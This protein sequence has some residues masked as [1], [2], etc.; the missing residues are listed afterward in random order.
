[1]PAPTERSP[2][3]AAPPRGPARPALAAG[4]LI[5]GRYR[6]RQPVEVPATDDEPADFWRADDETLERPVAI[7]L[8]PAGGQRGKAATAP[9]LAAAGRAARL[10]HPGLA[11]VYDAGVTTLPSRRSGRP[12]DIAYVVTEWVDAPPLADLLAAGP[13]PPP[14]ATALALQAAEAL[15]ALHDAGLTHG[16]VH[17]GNLLVDGDRA[18][19]TDAVV[20]TALHDWADADPAE[21]VRDLCAVLYAM[22]T[23]RW[24]ASAT[25]QPSRGVPAAPRAAG[26]AQV[27]A[28]R[29]VR[30]GIPR[31][32][33]TLVL[34]GLQPGRGLGSGGELAA[35]L[36]A[37]DLGPPEAPPSPP[38]V[39]RPA[40]R[41][42]RRALP[43]LATV[44][45]LVL[46]GAVLYQVGQRVGQLPRRAGA[47]DELVDPTTAPSAGAGATINLG[48]APVVV[49]DLEPGAGPESRG[50]VPNA[51]DGDPTT[52]WTTNDYRS[53]TFGGLTS[54]VGLLVDLGRPTALAAVKAGLSRPGA[55]VELRAA[56]ARGA[57]SADYTLVARVGRAGQ[58]ADLVPSTRTPARFWLVWITRL[59][60]APDGL[61]RE[62]IAELVF[63]RG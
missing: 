61:Y 34:R 40:P 48:A 60:R 41:W 39:R 56:D 46:V 24:P 58:V 5:A 26:G 29:Q 42:L 51:F 36:A 8:L 7:R 33:D 27:Y 3:P 1:M 52:A 47:I 23:G 57:T 20:A 63:V 32:L 12:T 10:G 44:G 4:D 16:R 9:F 19:L 59:P 62:G 35:A 38:R 50:S 2:A 43:L 15:A 55:D 25:D 45:F 18:R 14:A 22:L 53:P 31:A 21:D 11:R 17:P 6:L 37:V 28:P 49:R 54:G 13:L 30:A